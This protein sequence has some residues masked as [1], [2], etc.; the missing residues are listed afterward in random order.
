MLLD[1]LK[2]ADEVVITISD[3]YISSR[4]WD[5]NGQRIMTLYTYDGKF[6]KHIIIEYFIER[7]WFW[8]KNHEIIRCN[9]APKNYI[10][11]LDL[12]WHYIPHIYNLNITHIFPS[13]VFDKNPEKVQIFERLCEL[14]RISGRLLEGSPDKD[15]RFNYLP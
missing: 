12:D 13:Y 6:I 1:E 10:S 2:Y 4:Y 14:R 15:C 7:R 3:T 8:K 9:K 11:T 5:G